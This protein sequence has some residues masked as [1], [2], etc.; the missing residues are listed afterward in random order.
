MRTKRPKR[1]APPHT[2]IIQKNCNSVFLRFSIDC[3]A[4]AFG[5]FG[6]PPHRWMDDG[7]NRHECRKTASKPRKDG[8]TAVERQA[9]GWV[10]S[11][12]A[13]SL[14]YPP[15]PKKTRGR[16]ELGTSTSHHPFQF[17]FFF[18]IFSEYK[19]SDSGKLIAHPCPF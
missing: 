6:V 9:S 15:T 12:K 16:V 17:F 8:I 2:R 13:K 1:T 14:K 4:G 18:L 3:N 5:A 11:A 19:T 10:L 7:K